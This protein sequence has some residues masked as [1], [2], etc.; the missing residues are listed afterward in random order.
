MQKKQLSQHIKQVLG[1][2]MSEDGSEDAERTPT[3]RRSSLFGAL[4]ETRAGVVGGARKRLASCC[5]GCRKRFMLWVDRHLPMLRP[6]GKVRA[7]WDFFMFLL[8]LYT[9]TVMPLEVAF[10]IR[11]PRLMW[12]VINL[13]ID[14]F[15]LLDVLVRVRTG[16]VKDGMLGMPS[17]AEPETLCWDRSRTAL[18]AAA[19]SGS[20]GGGAV[21]DAETVT[22][23]YLTTAFPA[24]AVSSFPYG[25][26]VGFYGLVR[27]EGETLQSESGLQLLKLM[28]LLRPTVNL[29]RGASSEDISLSSRLFSRIA[30]FNPGLVRVFQVTVLLLLACHWVGCIYWLVSS[31]EKSYGVVSLWQPGMIIEAQTHATRSGANQRLAARR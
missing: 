20:P 27:P 22:Y 12:Q 3:R 26:L 30:R 19:Y 31:V 24:D 8:M 4:G 18:H 21:R 13:S 29:M 25:W 16:F 1:R 14:I 15:F 17:P 5:A 11:E 28:R 23:R 7:I 9:A 2:R 10:Q 6:N